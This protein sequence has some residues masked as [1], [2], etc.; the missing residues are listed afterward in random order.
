MSHTAPLRLP[1]TQHTR[2]S[3]GARRFGYLVAITVNLVLL[4]LINQAPGWDVLTFLSP[5]TTQVIGWV[6]ASILVAV[7]A[8]LVYL[9]HDPPWLKPLGDA[10]TTAFGIVV[11]VRWWQV[12]PFT[13]DVTTTGWND[14]ARM[15]LAVAIVGS[16]IGVVSGLVG[17]ARRL[18]DR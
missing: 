1:Q 17:F 11:L 14:V 18:G 10:L 7:A 4:T 8:N 9:S 16:A 15:A 13:E 5:E 3:L 2:P 12:F 6:N